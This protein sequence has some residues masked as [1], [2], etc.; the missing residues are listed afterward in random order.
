MKQVFTSNP[1]KKKKA[2]QRQN[3]YDGGT[4]FPE[5]LGQQGGGG[6]NKIKNFI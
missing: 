2:S 5:P 6:G 1:K 4:W 3:P